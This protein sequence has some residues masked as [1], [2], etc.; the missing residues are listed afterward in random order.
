[1]TDLLTAAE[2][3]DLAKWIEA[4][5]YAEHLLARGCHG[6][7]DPLLLHEV[8]QTGRAAFE[9]FVMSNQRLAAWWARRRASR[10]AAGGLDVG[11]VQQS[12]VQVGA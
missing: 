3:T 1:M 10:R 12:G 9:R 6:V 4:G 5:L 2:E 11:C 7:H 8:A